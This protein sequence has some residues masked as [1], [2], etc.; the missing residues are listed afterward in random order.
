MAKLVSSSRWE[1]VSCFS[2]DG[3]YLAVEIEGHCVLAPE[4]PGCWEEAG[5][6]ASPPVKECTCG[7]G[8][9]GILGF[10]LCGLD[11]DWPP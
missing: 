4:L 2:A 7:P 11:E 5:D 3:F 8:P 1:L 9:P 6:S 10:V